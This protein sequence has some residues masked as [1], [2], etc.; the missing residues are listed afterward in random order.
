[1]LQAVLEEGAEAGDAPWAAGMAG[2]RGAGSCGWKW[3]SSSTVLAVTCPLSF[4]IVW[5]SPPV[6][7]APGPAELSRLYFAVGTK[8]L[9]AVLV[10]SQWLSKARC[11]AGGCLAGKALER[12]VPTEI[13]PFLSFG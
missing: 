13:K 6:S 9:R 2:R 4:G 12:L 3:G 7:C 11:T 5:C 1:M 8:H 10:L